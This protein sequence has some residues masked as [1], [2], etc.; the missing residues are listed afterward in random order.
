MSF[1]HLRA[2]P[3]ESSRD[4]EIAEDFV[5]QQTEQNQSSFP[6]VICLGILLCNFC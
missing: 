6:I 1:I 5:A 2:K 3:I 4:V